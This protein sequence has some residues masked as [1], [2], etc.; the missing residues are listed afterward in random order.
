MGYIYI[1][2]SPSGKSYVGQTTRPIEKRFKEHQNKKGRC[3][4][5]YNAIQKYGWE[6]IEKDWYECPDEDLNF[7]EELLVR[8]MGTLAPDGYNLKEGGDNGQMS[9]ESKQKCREAHLGE[10]NHNYG[11][12]LSEETKQKL[13]ES[14]K[15]EKSHMYGKKLSEESKQKM[16]EA[17]KGEKHPMYGKTLCEETKQKI[18]EA[19]QG[20]KNHRSKKVYQ[21]DIEGNLLRTFSTSEEAGRHLEKDG[22]NISACARGKRKTAYNFKWSYTKHENLVNM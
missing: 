21:Y 10:K 11:K 15:G 6:K 7:D 13:S 17:K 19:Q 12:P 3:V 9:E 1:L 22:S 2:T 8:E 14:Q 4:A 5:I 20:D 16:S 18:S